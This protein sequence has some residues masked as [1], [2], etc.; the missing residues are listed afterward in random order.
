M[1][2]QNGVVNRAQALELGASQGFI[3]ARL[4]RSDW[5]EICN[6]V[7]ASASSPRT[8]EQRL[9]AAILDHP[10]ALAAGRSAAFLHEFAGVRRSKPQVL[11]PYGGNNRSS[12]ARVVRARHFDMLATTRVQDFDCTSVAETI[13][14]LSLTEGPSTIER[15]V[16]D[17]LAAKKLVI[18]DF[19]PIFERLEFAR[20]RGLGSLRRIVGSRADDAYQP[21]TTQLERLL[22]RLL[23]H[24]ELPMYQRQVPFEYPTTNAT[25]DAYIPVWTLIVEG[26]GR[27]WHNRQADHDRDRLRDA[28]ALAAGYA[29]V[30][31]TWSMLRYQPDECLRRLL[32]IGRHRPKAVAV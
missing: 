17:Q 26:D 4:E 21:P 3:R 19:N 9:R 27:R 5:I 14:T 18:A 1:A 20:Q 28:E 2:R 24:D 8:W 11:I 7:Y 29:V 25:V 10:V 23:D 30:R 12:V 15:F 22:Y 31:F 6:S 32:A 13:L 16:D